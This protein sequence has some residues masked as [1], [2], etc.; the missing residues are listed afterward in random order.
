MT[1]TV[2]VALLVPAVVL[3][4]AGLEHVSDGGHRLSDAIRAHGKLRTSP[5]KP[6]VLLL[7]VV[8]FVVALGMLAVTTSI[9]G[10]I[11]LPLIASL[12]VLLASVGMFLGFAAYAIH[13]LRGG[14]R[15]S[16]GCSAVGAPASKWLVSRNLVLAILPLPAVWV[17]ATRGAL[18]VENWDASF[19][20][21]GMLSSLG[22]AAILLHFPEAL[23]REAE[24]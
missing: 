18:H 19:S 3:L 2:G 7:I 21:I 4:L 22:L 5:T 1:L 8:E 11:E 17:I 24:R 14:V 6:I 12:L 15:T 23:H 10:W 13:L 20:L 16:C 9:I